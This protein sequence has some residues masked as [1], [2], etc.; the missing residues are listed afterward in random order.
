MPILEKTTTFLR[1]SRLELKKVTWP[2]REETTRH[3][4]TVILISAT[5][6]VFLG[7]LDFV[8]Q[9]ILNNFVL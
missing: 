2:S 3:T 6:A 4:L 9:F 1:E 5:V 8:F 7:G